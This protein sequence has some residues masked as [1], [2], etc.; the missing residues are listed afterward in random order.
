NYDYHLA[1][2]SP[3]ID[4]GVA[5]GAPTTD[6]EGV[7]RNGKPDMGAYEVA[8]VGTHQPGAKAL[9]LRLVPNPT[10]ERSFLQIENDWSGEV[11]VRVYSQAGALVR[12]FTFLKSPGAWSQ[13]IDVRN[14]P[15]GIYLVRAQASTQVYEG[16]I[17][18]Q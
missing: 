6:I 10:V 17:V 1:A 2:G 4:Q 3:C 15:V 9:E 14:L 13:S 12:D 16:Q 7:A 5:A 8:S 11:N 18:K